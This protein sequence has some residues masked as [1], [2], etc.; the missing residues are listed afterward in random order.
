MIRIPGQTGRTHRPS[1]KRLPGTMSSISTSFILAQGWYPDNRSQTKLKKA[2]RL[3]GRLARYY[4][5]SLASMAL[6]TVSRFRRLDRL[7]GQ[8]YSVMRASRIQPDHHH[9]SVK[10]KTLP[11]SLSLSHPSALEVERTC[12]AYI[13]PS[14]PA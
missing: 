6:L 9:I 14:L 12:F 11:C 10:P 8:I 13:I 3:I 5:Q 1:S 4:M 2:V 7:R